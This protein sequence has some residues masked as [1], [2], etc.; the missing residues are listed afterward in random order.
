MKRRPA[1]ACFDRLSSLGAGL[2]VEAL[3]KL[4]QGTLTPEKQPEEVRRLM[5]RRSAKRR[6]RLTGERVQKRLSA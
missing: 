4:E 3:E 5:Q 1:A 2:L 6:E